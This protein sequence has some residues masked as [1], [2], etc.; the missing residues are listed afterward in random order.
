MLEYV[1]IV[2]MTVE[3]VV[4]IGAGILASSF[5]LIAFGSDSVIELASA[6]V[7][8]RH[9]R[10]DGGGSTTQGEKEA[11]LTSLLLMS[12]VPIIGASS[13]YSYFFLKI[14]PD[15]SLPGLLLAAG[16]IVV[17]PYLWRQKRKIGLETGCIPLS[18]D[19]LESATCFF[20]SIALFAGL[21]LNFL[22]RVG[23]FDYGAT[24]VILAFIGFEARESYLEARGR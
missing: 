16:A 23:W 6:F 11:L 3:V 19:A 18:I 1:S 7:V 17:M 20:M 14:R 15:A 10:F 8:L 12:I 4:A 5:A 21:L 9:L 13:T 2:W 24:L 22:F